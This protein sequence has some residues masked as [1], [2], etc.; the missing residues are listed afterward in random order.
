VTINAVRAADLYAYGGQSNVNHPGAVELGPDTV[1]ALCKAELPGAVHTVTA[2]G[3]T[4]W[5]TRSPT[6]AGREDRLIGSVSGARTFID[7]GGTAD[8]NSI[9]DA[10]TIIGNA[11]AYWSARIAA[12]F[13]RVIATT[14][15]VAGSFDAPELTKRT[16][17]NSGLLALASGTVTVI[18]LDAYGAVF[19]VPTDPV[20]WQGDLLHWTAASALIV[21]LAVM[22]AL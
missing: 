13:D 16:A 20:Y 8:I 17:V 22:A 1:P 4:S 2:I 5:P 19:T 14:V 21:H 12:G 11:G 3:G 15:P 7:I 18:D 9:A 6:A 10:A